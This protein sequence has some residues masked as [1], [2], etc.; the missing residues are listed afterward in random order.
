[1][2]SLQHEPSAHAPWTRTMF[3]R[4]VMSCPPLGV[5]CPCQIASRSAPGEPGLAA[6]DEGVQPLASVLCAEQLAHVGIQSSE[7]DLLALEPGAVRRREC[8]LD[9]ERS[10]FRGDGVR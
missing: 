10:G 8:G 1:M 3:G 4:S 5:P 2:T 6:L 9:A 7:R